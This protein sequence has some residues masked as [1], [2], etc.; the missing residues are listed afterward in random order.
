MYSS[1]ELLTKCGIGL[2]GSCATSKGY[3]SCIDGTFL[4]QDQI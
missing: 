2:C 4:R 3:R 1:I